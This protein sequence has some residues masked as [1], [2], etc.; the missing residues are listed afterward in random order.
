[1][2]FSHEVGKNGK[3]YSF[4][5]MPGNLAIFERNMLLNPELSRII[6]LVRMPL[7]S[8]SGEQLFVEGNGPASKVVSNS[9]RPDATR[10]ETISIDDLASNEKLKRVDFIKMDIEGAEL[11]A[12]R[13]AE[14]TIRQFRP[15]MA[16]SLYHKLNDFW[17]IPQYLDGLGLGYK[18]TLRHFTIH[19][20]ETVLFVY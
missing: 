9:I 20:E 4:E 5:F 8:I 14:R 13:G 10:V 19:A 7:W 16:I 11:E 12:L 6:N 1:M 18:F 17:E 3:V 15:K 2:Y